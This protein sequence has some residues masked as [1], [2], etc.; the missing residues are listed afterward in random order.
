[1]TT[2]MERFD[3]A[4]P[5]KTRQVIPPV[6]APPPP[7]VPQP[8]INPD[9]PYRMVPPEAYEAWRRG[10]DRDR[11]LGLTANPVAA[12]AAPLPAPPTPAAAFPGAGAPPV[13]YSP[14]PVVEAAPGTAQGIS[15]NTAP[16]APGWAGSV[17]MSAPEAVAYQRGGNEAKSMAGLEDIVKGFKGQE[18]KSS[19]LNTITPISGYGGNTGGGGQMSAQLLA[20]MLENARKNY[21][22]TLT[23]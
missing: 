8:V 14:K 7:P 21:G 12:P 2:F 20:Q 17:G 11:G 19:D 16:V 4:F 18:A 10:A 1:M 15:L 13:A 22:M 5:Q 6:V 3:A 9:E 23:G